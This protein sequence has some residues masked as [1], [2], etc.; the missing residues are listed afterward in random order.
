MEKIDLLYLDNNHQ[1]TEEELIKNLSINMDALDEIYE[2]NSQYQDSLGWL[3]VEE[4]AGDEAISHLV[5][6]AAQIRKEADV[7]VLI[8]V[9][10]SNQAARAVVQALQIDNKPEILY[11]GNNI[12]A[13]YVNKLLKKLEGKSVYINVIAKNF[14]TLEPGIGFRVLRKYLEETYGEAAKDRIT[15]TG[16]IG[17]SLNQ[18]AKDNGYDFLVFPENIG[19]RYSVLSDVGLFPMAVAGIDIKALVQGARDM[20]TRLF[21]ENNTDNIALRYAT[22]RNL[23][24]HKGYNLE[25]MA[26]FEEQLHYFSKWWI[27]LFAESEGKEGIGIYPVAVSYS[28][29]LHSIGQYVQEGQRMIFETFIDIQ[30]Q[31]SSVILKKDH[32]EDRFDY[33]ND[34]DFWDINKVAFEATLE[35]HSESGIPCMKFILPRLDEYYFGQMF[36]MFEFA[37]YL[38]GSVLGINPFD[39]PGVENYKGY[40]FK[41]LGK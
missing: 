10:G 4:W 11:A 32:V 31:N 40:M 37:C 14:E 9:G 17:S 20:K 8:G 39:Q 5:K 15:V 33:L 18:V 2:N 13:H 3:N 21:S 27:Q 19:G 28:E 29:D 26:F 36:Y 23:L 38:S 41:K 22:Y 35:A 1:I 30:E 6:K 34:K 25:M 12:S 24:L 16:T 7:F